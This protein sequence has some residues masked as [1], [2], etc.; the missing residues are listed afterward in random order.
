MYQLLLSSLTL[1]SLLLKK[2]MH[3]DAPREEVI[4]CD[5]VQKQNKGLQYWHPSSS[6]LISS[7]SFFIIYLF[8]TLFNVWKTGSNIIISSGHENHFFVITSS[9]LLKWIN[10]RGLAALRESPITVMAKGCQPSRRVSHWGWWWFWWEWNVG[11]IE[12]RT[13]YST[14]CF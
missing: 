6:S 3:Q 14:P 13:M 4:Q 5:Y 11:W 2:R 1:L 10:P 7:L 12:R 8:C 9:F